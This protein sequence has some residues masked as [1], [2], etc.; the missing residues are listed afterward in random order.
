MLHGRS[1]AISF[2]E[3]LC[4]FVFGS[5]ELNCAIAGPPKACRLKMGL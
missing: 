2:K 3:F 4:L 1:S 5:P